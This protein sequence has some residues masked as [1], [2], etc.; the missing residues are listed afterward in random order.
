MADVPLQ[1]LLEAAIGD[2]LG[3]VHVGGVGTITSYDHSTQTATVQPV[4]RSRF[5][6]PDTGEP[7]YIQP[8]PIPNVPV[9]FPEG[10]GSSIVWPLNQG[11]TVYLCQADKSHDEWQ[12]TGSD[13]ETPQDTRRFDLTDAFAF[14]TGRSPADP[15]GSDARDASAMVVK[16]ADELHLGR[17]N[18]TDATGQAKWVAIANLV[19]DRISRNEK[20]YNAH[21]HGTILPLI[22]APSPNPGPTMPVGSP[23]SPPTDPQL[24]TT[25][26]ADVK[27]DKVKSE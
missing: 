11:D 1:E 12:A 2:A 27:S 5:V 7:E 21:V 8:P 25:K 10:G 23:P 17:A 26:T 9:Q 3:S 18:P 19:A 15:V 24:P 22:P 4:V 13:D 6:D 20:K 16:L 14:P